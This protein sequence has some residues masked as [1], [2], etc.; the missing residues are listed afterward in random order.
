MFQ[1]DQERRL[2][3]VVITIA[4]LHST[5]PLMPPVEILLFINSQMRNSLFFPYVNEFE[6][7]L[8]VGPY[9][10]I[11][12]FFFPMWIFNGTGLIYRPSFVTAVEFTLKSES[13]QL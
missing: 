6:I 9:F 7:V 8:N 10:E 3:V 12:L 4:Q 13:P 11:Y 1:F 5:K 2:G